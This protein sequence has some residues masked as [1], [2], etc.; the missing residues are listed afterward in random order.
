VASADIPKVFKFTELTQVTAIPTTMFTL[1]SPPTE[2]NPLVFKGF[3]KGYR[4]LEWHHVNGVRPA[5]L[6][7]PIASGDWSGLY[8]HVATLKGGTLEFDHIPNKVTWG[9]VMDFLHELSPTGS[10]FDNPEESDEFFDVQFS[11]CYS[12]L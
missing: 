9:D 7:L 3:V 1:K 2:E 11:L 12:Q 10:N 4:H 8:I 6:D 5:F